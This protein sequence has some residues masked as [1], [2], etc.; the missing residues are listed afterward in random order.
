MPDTK[1]DNKM[2]I[3][4]DF[5]LLLVDYVKK[6]SDN[7]IFFNIKYKKPNVKLDSHKQCNEFIKDVVDTKKSNVYTKSIDI[8]A[9]YNKWAD[10]KNYE[11]ISKGEFNKILKSKFYYSTSTRIG[12]I[13]TSG[14]K[15]IFKK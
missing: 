8:F 4:N 7:N 14:F 9:E 1:Y 10:N 2:I 3:E 5:F 12:S 13:V 11:H 6:F 15:L